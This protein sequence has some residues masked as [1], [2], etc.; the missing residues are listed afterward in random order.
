MKKP[1]AYKVVYDRLVVSSDIPRL[2]N[3]VARRIRVAVG[4]KL[5]SNPHIY[6]EPLRSKLGRYW[7]LRVGD[8]RVIYEISTK[9]V[10][11]FMIGHRGDIYKK[12]QNRI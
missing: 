11:I 1:G 7:K 4:A 2:D 9:E 6:G 12:I 3:S 8:W 5:T 10:R